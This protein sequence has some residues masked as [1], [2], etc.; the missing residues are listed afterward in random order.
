MTTPGVRHRK[1]QQPRKGEGGNRVTTDVTATSAR[2]RCIGRRPRKKTE[3]EGG[4]P[5]EPAKA[6]SKP[7]PRGPSRATAQLFRRNADPISEINS[8]GGPC[9]TSNTPRHKEPRRANQGCLALR[10]QTRAS[11]MNTPDTSNTVRA[12]RRR[13]FVAGR[14]EFRD[15][16]CPYGHRRARFFVQQT[17]RCRKDPKSR[18]TAPALSMYSGTQPRLMPATD[19]CQQATPRSGQ[20]QPISSSTSPQRRWV[21]CFSRGSSTQHSG[22][23]NDWDL[24]IRFH[25]SR[26]AGGV[27]PCV[28]KQRCG[29]R[30]TGPRS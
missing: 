14:L 6:T 11:R 7:R 12:L 18:Q 26:V 30:R 16:G 24:S 23:G 8:V 22:K 17:I 28:R 27:T 19:Q 1:T 3:L 5:N 29:S 25:C 13:I 21:P 10:R 4:S 9:P 15:H 2:Q 20:G